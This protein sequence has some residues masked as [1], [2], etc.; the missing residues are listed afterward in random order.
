[1]EHKNAWLAYDEPQLAELEKLAANYIEFISANKTERECV[2]TAIEQAREAGYISLDEASNSLRA[3]RS[4]PSCTAKPSSWR[5][6]AAV[7][8]RTA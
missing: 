3:T 7:P 1:M 6:S 5:T 8:C 4:T 2:A